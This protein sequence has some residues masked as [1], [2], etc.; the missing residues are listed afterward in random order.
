MLGLGILLLQV[1][2]RQRPAPPQELETAL[3]EESPVTAA[4]GETAGE[5]AE[6]TAIVEEAEEE[7]EAPRPEEE[8]A[9]RDSA[10][11]E[12]D[13]PRGLGEGPRAGSSGPPT[14]QPLRVREPVSVLESDVPLG[15]SHSPRTAGTAGSSDLITTRVQGPP[16]LRVVL[17]SGPAGGPYEQVT[18]KARSGGRWEGWLDYDVPAGQVIEY[19]IVASHPSVTSQESS[20]S[21]SNPHQVVV[22]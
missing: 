5:L 13:Q 1:L 7:E 22:E 3:Q 16:G 19:W 20:G 14:E 4:P 10:I 18:L 21:R 2:L 12:Q 11:V 9:P 6:S 8:S 17:H 15:L